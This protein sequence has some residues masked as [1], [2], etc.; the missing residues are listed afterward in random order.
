MADAQLHKSRVGRTGSLNAEHNRRSHRSASTVHAAWWQQRRNIM[1]ENCGDAFEKQRTGNACLSISTCAAV[2]PQPAGHR[3]TISEQ[4]CL[5]PFV[6]VRAFLRNTKRRRRV[7]PGDGT[8]LMT[9]FQRDVDTLV[10]AP[11]SRVG[12]RHFQH[13]GVTK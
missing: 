11:G 5:F 6:R 8:E 7:H 9:L 4:H 3:E 10:S 13:E 12:A 1:E 2:S